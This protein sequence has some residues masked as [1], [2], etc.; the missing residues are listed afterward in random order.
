MSELIS[1]S[2]PATQ[3]CITRKLFKGNS[4][5][6]KKNIKTV[7]NLHQQ[8]TKNLHRHSKKSP[9]KNEATKIGHPEKYHS[10]IYEKSLYD[11]MKILSF[12]KA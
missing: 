8:T 3:R 7:S 4:E 11:L 9:N 1:P 2:G 10:C 6:K 12:Q 5:K